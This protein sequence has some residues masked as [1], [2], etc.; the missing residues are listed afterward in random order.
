MES[1][2]GREDPGKE[3]TFTLASDGVNLGQCVCPLIKELIG[4]LWMIL[5][6]WAGGLQ[7]DV[8]ASLP[9]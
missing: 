8:P 7:V 6:G 3:C 5:E 9:C 1:V 2:S 4:C